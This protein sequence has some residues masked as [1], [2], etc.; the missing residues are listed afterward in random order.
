MIFHPF[1]YYKFS[2]NYFSLLN[3]F[4]SYLII[5]FLKLSFLYHDLKN[6][7]SWL[8]GRY[9]EILFNDMQIV[10]MGSRLTR[11]CVQ[12]G[13][14]EGGE[15]NDRPIGQVRRWCYALAERS[16]R[17]TSLRNAH[18]DRARS[19]V[20]ERPACL[21][22]VLPLSGLWNA[23]SLYVASRGGRRRRVRSGG[24]GGN[25][26]RKETAGEESRGEGPLGPQESRARGKIKGAERKG[27]GKA[28]NW[29]KR[30]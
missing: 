1:L 19:R 25:G 29:V 13:R 18:A 7:R 9:I 27:R 16:A 3:Y 23:T 28:R 5:P 26:G 8:P 21:D 14:V 15:S 10:L 6:F 24:C 17:G 2:W 30:R 22:E 11:R 4:I 20:R 12:F